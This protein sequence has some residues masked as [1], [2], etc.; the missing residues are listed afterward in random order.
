MLICIKYLKDCHSFLPGNIICRLRCKTLLCLSGSVLRGSSNLRWVLHYGWSRRIPSRPSWI[1]I[2]FKIINISRRL[3]LI[4]S[5]EGRYRVLTNWIIPQM[6]MIIPHRDNLGPQIFMMLDYLYK[7]C[8]L[9]N[10][11]K[12]E[13]ARK[14]IVRNVVCLRSIPYPPNIFFSLHGNLC[15]WLLLIRFGSAQC[16]HRTV[17]PDVTRTITVFHNYSTQNGFC[18]VVVKCGKWWKIQFLKVVLP[19]CLSLN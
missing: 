12:G 18:P 16:G 5:I 1:H 7:Y 11:L 4:L 19:N 10:I 9:K 8:S 17:P 14:I 2:T 3:V 13:T 6:L 15:F